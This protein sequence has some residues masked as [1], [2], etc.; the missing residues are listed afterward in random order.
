MADDKGMCRQSDLVEGIIWAVDNGARIINISIELSDYTSPLK[1]AIDYAWEN[2]AIVIAAAGNEGSSTPVYPA[3]F[4]NCLSVTGIDEVL[5]IAPLANYGDWVDAAAPGF[6]IYGVLPGDSYGY[7][8]GTS[9]AT[10]YVSGLA[11]RLF[12]LAEDTNGNGYVND[13]VLEAILAGC[14]E[15]PLE[16][17]GH[18]LID[19]SGSQKYLLSRIG[20]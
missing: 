7:Q 15:L 17:T 4:D 8:H 13:E 12:S 11:A 5:E 20:E 9:F 1:E 18:G 6:R 14:R 2:G 10:A 16:G 3:A 19:V